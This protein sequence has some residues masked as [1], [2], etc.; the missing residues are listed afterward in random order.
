MMT[1]DGK[2]LSL[3]LATLLLS[4]GASSAEPR[5]GD[6][7]GTKRPRYV[8]SER[9]R[10]NGQENPGEAR[11]HR[12]PGPPPT[13]EQFMK[14]FDLDQDGEVTHEEFMKGHQRPA[15][16]MPPAPPP[17]NGN[18]QP[19]PPRPVNNNGNDQP[20]PKSHDDLFDDLDADG[21]GQLSREE[22]E[23]LKMP[24]MP[25]P[26]AQRFPPN[27]EQVFQ[28]LDANHDG[29]I[30]RE[31]HDAA[32]MKGPPGRHGPPSGEKPAEGGEASVR[33]WSQ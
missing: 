16:D 21:N 25:A 27:P 10:D 28:H 5:P 14:R 33:P 23:E 11:G 1:C 13:T 24:R 26:P 32:A 4:G 12:P 19:P 18:G 20:P 6:G 15:G 29:K 17:T 7:H 2:L 8:P 3:C 30:T 9:R 22:F 31:E